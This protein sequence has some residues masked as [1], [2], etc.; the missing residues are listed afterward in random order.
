MTNILQQ[1]PK[2]IKKHLR[3][4]A[5][6]FRKIVTL[7]PHKRSGWEVQIE[8]SVFLFWLAA[9]T[10]YRVAGV[11]F[12]IPRTTVKRICSKMLDFCV[13]VLMLQVIKYPTEHEL[14]EIGSRFC[15]RANTCIFERAVGAID[16][17]HVRIRCP[18]ALHDQYINRKLNYS[19]QCQAVCDSKFKFVDICVGFPGSVHDT[20]VMY[21]SP[22]YYRRLYPPPGYYLL[23]DSGYPCSVYPIAIITPFKETAS[24]RLTTMEK[25]FNNVHSKA[26]TVV[27][28][29]FGQLKTRWRSI[30]N[31]DLE[32][33]IDNSVKVI[34]ACCVLHNICI[35]EKDVMD[36]EPIMEDTEQVED[37]TEHNRNGERPGRDTGE[38]IAF[39]QALLEQMMSQI[40]KSP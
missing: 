36:A 20:R 26:R 8:L 40:N 18:P 28:C 14:F 24:R 16:G 29:A 23:G 4:S 35:D 30:F 10:S 11:A 3:V 9:G 39:R 5:E 25:K 13:D 32:L 37:R 22:L 17:S 6:V 12:D 19:I 38:G 1:D 2:I 7:I 27:E 33:R 15:N 34:V 21:N 31:K